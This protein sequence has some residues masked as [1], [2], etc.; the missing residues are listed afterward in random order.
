M[1]FDP[2]LAAN[3]Q[4]QRLKSFLRI[5]I[6]IQIPLLKFA[7]ICIF[8][9]QA[10]F[11]VQLTKLHINMKENVISWN[12][13]NTILPSSLSL[14]HFKELQC[15]HICVGVNMYGYKHILV[16]TLEILCVQRSSQDFWLSQRVCRY[17]N[18]YSS[19][20]LYNLKPRTST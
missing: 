9:S 20:V 7:A 11:P 5:L 16:P 4:D 10:Y 1:S 17:R 8:N 19:A 6:Y 14:N 13:L 18:S 12:R 2:C 15:I 3:F